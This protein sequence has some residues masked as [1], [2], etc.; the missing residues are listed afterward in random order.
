MAAKASVLLAVALGF[1]AL[2]PRNALADTVYSYPAYP[3][4]TSSPLYTVK[5]NRML[6]NQPILPIS[7]YT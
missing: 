2:S 5:A 3:G 1:S 4:A 6:K 7:D